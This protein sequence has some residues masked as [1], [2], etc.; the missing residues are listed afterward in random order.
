MSQQRREQ[1]APLWGISLLFLG[2]VFLL[3]TLNILPWGLWSILWR[4]WPVLGI[5]IGLSILL[6]RYSTWLV[7]ALFM[8]ML[9]ASLGIAIWQY[10]ATPQQPPPPPA[11]SYTQPLGNF[12][13]AQVRFDFDAG[14]LGM[15]ALGA[16]SPNLVEAG[17]GAITA[18]FQTQ[19]SE[20]LLVLKNNRDRGLEANWDVRL[21]RNI[22]LSVDVKSAASNIDLDLSDLKVVDFRLKI[23][24]SN[25]NVRMPASSALS[26]F[27]KSA[28]SNL[29][30]TIPDGVSVRI[31]AK[32]TLTAFSV[33]ERRFPRKGDFY[34]SPDFDGAKYRIELTIESD[35]GKVDVR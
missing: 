29:D 24:A 33:D 19:G 12:A 31:K 15:N 25:G 18:D 1:Y 11:K 28:V 20:G 21:T 17:D 13:R 4:F 27:V 8:A 34:V 16:S 7:S 23:D 3:Q 14:R 35:L 32:T 22:P 30:I 26:A 5:M 9:L 10:G 2:I 6:R